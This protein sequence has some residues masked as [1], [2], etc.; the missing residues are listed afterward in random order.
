MAI[1]IRLAGEQDAEQTL[2]IYAP[3][4]QYTS[5]S[6]EMTPP[7]IYDMRQR[8][9]KTLE[10][11]PWL[12]CDAD[13]AVCG[14]AYANPHRVRA[15]YQWSVEVSV[16]VHP[17][18]RQRGVARGL[19]TSLTGLLKLQGFYNAFAGITLPNEGGV[20][21]HEA[22][23]FEEVGIYP[24]VAYK[25]GAWHDVAWWHLSLRDSVAAPEPLVHFPDLQASPDWEATITAGNA[26]LK[27]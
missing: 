25:L 5:C 24:N 22:T 20:R 23:G 12:S 1:T 18:Y 14:Y 15:A 10:R 7:T 9:T 8:I 11:L 4:V 3:V 13:G 19:Y 21:L 6:F 27:Q 16:Y 26:C 2:A 17:D